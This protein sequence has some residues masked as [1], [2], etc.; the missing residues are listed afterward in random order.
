LKR[1]ERIGEK[2]EKS[3]TCLGREHWMD[4]ELEQP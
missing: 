4:I 1:E 3:E 2:E